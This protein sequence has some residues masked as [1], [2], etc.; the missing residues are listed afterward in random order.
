MKESV[1][2]LAVASVYVCAVLSL[3]LSD[4][5]EGTIEALLRQKWQAYVILFILAVIVAIG[6]KLINWIFQKGE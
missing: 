6:H 5:G 2:R 3:F 1:R 4:I